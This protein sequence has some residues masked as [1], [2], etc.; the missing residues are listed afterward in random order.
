LSPSWSLSRCWSVAVTSPDQTRRQ[1]ETT[2]TAAGV[3]HHEDPA[4]L[5]RELR[6]GRVSRAAVKLLAFSGSDAARKV[7]PVD[8]RAGA[9]NAQITWLAWD[10]WDDP[11]AR[12]T[13]LM[14]LAEPLGERVWDGPCQA[15]GGSKVVEVGA[16]H[17]L[18]G[19]VVK[20][21]ACNG[22]GTVQHRQPWSRWLAVAVAVEV[23]RAC[24]ADIPS[25]LAG[26]IVAAINA[27]AAWLKE[28]TEENLR[29]WEWATEGTEMEIAAGGGAMLP[30]WV[31]HAWWGFVYEGTRFASDGPAIM[32][33]AAA[34]LTTPS[35]V[36][37]IGDAVV[38]R[39][40]LGEVRR[41]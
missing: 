20:C 17:S 3:E 18:P 23:A 29:T 39:E 21:P 35:R 13:A 34:Q 16:R 27:A 4:W 14:R 1:H 41:G 6:E 37:E 19:R 31:P 26:E 11:G 30:I 2:L 40:T 12:A 15:C 10:E 25:I 5:A 9:A 38:L 22:S 33:Q 7:I 32:A 28:P 24:A 8:A 36:R